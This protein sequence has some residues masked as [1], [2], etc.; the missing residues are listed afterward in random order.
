[1]S[2]REAGVAAFHLDGGKGGRRVAFTLGNCSDNVLTV[3]QICLEVAGCE[4]WH[5]PPYL[6][7]KVTP[8]RYEIELQPFHLG[9]YV[10]TEERFRYAGHDAD[11]FDLLCMSPGGFKYKVRLKIYYSDLATKKQFTVYSD[12]FDLYFYKKGDLSQTDL[13]PKD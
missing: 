12:A 8:L 6:E 2:I 9:E 1:M 5:Q 11:D 13:P 3:E 4:L 10:V 7:A